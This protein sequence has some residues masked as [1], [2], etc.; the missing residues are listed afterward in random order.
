[1]CGYVIYALAEKGQLTREKWEPFLN[2]NTWTTYLLP[3]IKG[4]LI[5][6]GISI[7]LALILGILFGVGRMSSN[8]V[9]SLCCGAVVEFFRA[10]PML[11][12][13][14]FCFALYASLGLFQADDLAL[15]AV[16]TGLTLCNGAVIAELV[17]AGVKA[18]PR[19]QSEA[20]DALGLSQG[21]R[22]RMIL[23]PQAITSM[24]PPL[25]SQM[26]VV[27]KDTALGYQVT[28][29]ET[30]RQG[31]QTGSAFSNYIPSLIVI[32]VIMIVINFGLGRLTV[33]IERRLRSKD[34]PAR[35]AKPASVTPVPVPM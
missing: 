2:S 24:L 6:A 27:L 28:Y 25:V 3:G 12:V 29:V 5:A 22:M 10:I 15:A 26:V 35:P 32:A 31:V 19:G 21:Q 34:R 33:A 20:A 7:V 13:M 17:R 30:V 18:L 8:R 4:T 23:L 14:I 11:I 1:M 16:V 9:I